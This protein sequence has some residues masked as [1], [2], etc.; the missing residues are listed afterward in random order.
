MGTSAH[1]TQAL[2]PGPR[3]E[4]RHGVDNREHTP[5]T[6]Q[7]Q[8]TM[9]EAAV[10]SHSSTARI[11]AAGSELW[12]AQLTAGQRAAVMALARYG[13]AVTTGGGL[14]TGGPL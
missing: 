13:S 7:D 2:K 8:A 5:T 9:P 14:W 3:Q 10:P 6:F 1:P 11:V 4:L 12:W